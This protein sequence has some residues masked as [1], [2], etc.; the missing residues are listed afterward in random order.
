[1]RSLELPSGVVAVH[2]EGV[3]PTVVLLHANP[4]DAK[5]W[6]AV[7]PTLVASGRRV[8]RL[9]WPGFGASPVPDMPGAAS[10]TMFA[11]VLSEALPYLVPEGERATLVGNSV[12]GF[13]ALTHALDKPDSVAGLVLVA[14]GG[15]TSLNPVTVHSGG[16]QAAEPS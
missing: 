6:A 15:F 8:L 10:A 11:T 2:E 7:A 13:A 5:D 4:G 1:M 14:P 16:P 3:G 9:D 12:G